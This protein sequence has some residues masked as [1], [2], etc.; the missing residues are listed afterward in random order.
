MS[1]L[2]FASTTYLKDNCVKIVLSKSGL[3]RG[4]ALI[5]APDHVYTELIKIKWNRF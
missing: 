5:T 2:V 3:L 1:F 4:F